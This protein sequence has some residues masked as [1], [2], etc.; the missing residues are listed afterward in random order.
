M[1]VMLF[2]DLFASS[3]SIKRIL[4]YYRCLSFKHFRLY[5]LSFTVCFRTYVVV[6]ANLFSRL[7][8]FILNNTS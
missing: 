3:F 7:C 4:V 6:V 8:L 5:L 2:G 1:L